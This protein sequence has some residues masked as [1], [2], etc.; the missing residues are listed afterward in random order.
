MAL[1]GMFSKFRSSQKK[2][3]G[4]KPS[5]DLVQSAYEEGQKRF[6]QDHNDSKH[7]T[8]GQGIGGSSKSS[9]Q[10]TKSTTSVGTP[11]NSSSRQYDEQGNVILSSSTGKVLS[12]PPKVRRTPIEKDPAGDFTNEKSPIDESLVQDHV[13]ANNDGSYGD[14]A[15]RKTGQGYFFDPSDTQGGYYVSEDGVHQP[16]HHPDSG[17]DNHEDEALTEATR[18]R[19]NHRPDLKTMPSEYRRQQQ[20]EEERQKL[21]QQQQDQQQDQHDDSNSLGRE[22]SNTRSMNQLSKSSTKNSNSLDRSSTRTT[23]EEEHKQNRSTYNPGGLNALILEKSIGSKKDSSIENVS[24]DLTN[25]DDNNDVNDNDDINIA[26]SGQ[27]KQGGQAVQGVQSTQTSQGDDTNASTKA[28]KG[29]E[30]PDKSNK[31]Q[32][33]VAG[34]TAGAAG[35]AATAMKMA[36][37]GKHEEESPEVKQAYNEG[38]ISGAYDSGKKA[39]NDAATEEVY[40]QGFTSGAYDSGKAHAHE[41]NAKAFEKHDDLSGSTDSGKSIETKPLAFIKDDPI[42]RTAFQSDEVGSKTLDPKKNSSPQASKKDDDDDDSSSKV[43]FLAGA[44]GAVGAVGALAASTLGFGGDDS[45]ETKITRPEDQLLINNS[46]EAGKNKA[47]KDHYEKKAKDDAEA[48]NQEAQLLINQSYEA[49]KDKG[50]KDHE[51]KKKSIESNHASKSHDDHVALGAVTPSGSEKV[52]R[53]SPEAGPPGKK[54]AGSAI[55]GAGAVGAAAVGAAAGLSAKPF[56]KDSDSDDDVLTGS[57]VEESRLND[58]DSKAFYEAGHTNS[59]QKPLS[60]TD[61]KDYYNAGYTN[62][63]SKPLNA[64]DVDDFY[65]TGYSKGKE[66][67]LLKGKTLNDSQITDYYKAGYVAGARERDQPKGAAS[68]T[69]ASSKSMGSDGSE[70]PSDGLVIEVVGVEDR[71]MAAR[72]AKKASKELQAQGVDLSKGKLV[73]NAETKQVYKIDDPNG[74]VPPEIKEVSGTKGTSST[75][76]KQPSGDNE[77]NGKAVPNGTST[78]AAAGIGSSIAAGTAFAGL[79]ESRNKKD[80]SSPVPANEGKNESTTSQGDVNN[81]KSDSDIVVTV[82]GA[83]NDREAG[84]VANSVVMSLKN[85]PKVLNTVKELRIDANSG[86]VTDENGNVVTNGSFFKNDSPPPEPKTNGGVGKEH[87]N[88]AHGASANVTQPLEPELED[89][90]IDDFS[91]QGNGKVGDSSNVMSNTEN[92]D[93]LETLDPKTKDAKGSSSVGAGVGTAAGIGAAAAA[94]GASGFGKGKSNV[95]GDSTASATNPTPANSVSYPK[96]SPEAKKLEHLATI[97]QENEA[98]LDK[99]LAAINENNKNKLGQSYYGYSNSK[100]PSIDETAKGNAKDSSL[101]TINDISIRVV[102]CPAHIETKLQKEK[103]DYISKHPE[104]V[105]A[106]TKTITFD[107]KTGIAYD[108]TGKEISKLSTLRSY[109]FDENVNKQDEIEMPG[110]FFY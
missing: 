31:D 108:G 77:S 7:N 17:N 86:I 50:L 75:G 27:D 106:D 5:D 35:V 62:S 69:G 40:K 83:K 104:F 23:P 10:L 37:F 3:D 54:A 92:L 12:T 72:L 95:R 101:K 25:S 19:L 107:A 63:S 73:V 36:G 16:S 91:F 4:K 44:T 59:K 52:E 70:S 43:G 22:S 30:V 1:S 21:L 89:K 102:G 74:E 60:D 46:Y 49:G 71:K 88:P 98:Q 61:Y 55:G 29:E 33:I 84:D 100:N 45:K 76:S 66:S 97:N 65:G 64:N 90:N 80:K 109:S 87:F 42:N 58:K 41:I 47:V 94:V 32:G 26:S 28:V 39:A 15:N 24:P 11:S 53:S 38:F 110:S 13:Y 2:K 81:K 68:N 67:E 99:K 103:M 51:Q 14:D 78:A 93:N 34:V 48:R 82:Q 20:Q 6:H 105:P 56:N 57:K 9:K 96:D 18:A 8:K 79:H 85:N